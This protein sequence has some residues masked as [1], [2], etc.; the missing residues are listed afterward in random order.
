MKRNLLSRRQVVDLSKAVF[1]FEEYGITPRVKD[2][3]L[4]NGWRFLSY[5][6]EDAYEV[7]SKVEI[8]TSGYRL[9]VTI[10]QIS[11][12]GVLNQFSIK[13]YAICYDSNSIS[14][15]PVYKSSFGIIQTKF[16]EEDRIYIDNSPSGLL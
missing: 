4:N 14:L 7:D 15:F 11:E 9:M 10:Y 3:R 8:A 13:D 6:F 2:V 1:N 16:T 5:Y 12:L